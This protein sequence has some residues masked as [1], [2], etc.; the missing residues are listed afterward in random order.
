MNK[1]D[2]ITL[3]RNVEGEFAP[4]YWTMSGGEFYTMLDAVKALSFRKWQDSERVW[5]VKFD[6]IATLREVGYTV[7]RNA[8]IH[9]ELRHGAESVEKLEHGANAEIVLNYRIG[10]SNREEWAISP[11]LLPEFHVMLHFD[12]APEEIATLVEEERADEITQKHISEKNMDS[13]CHDS[14]IFKLT[15]RALHELD[16]KAVA[17][18]VEHR[19]KRTKEEHKAAVQKVWDFILLEGVKQ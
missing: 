2:S 9:V 1:Q 13:F 19:G 18:Y 6:G 10:V 3:K 12:F 4:Q 5:L 17:C 8:D 16:E 7:T 15:I 14:A 11:V